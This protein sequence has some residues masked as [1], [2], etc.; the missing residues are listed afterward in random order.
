MGGSDSISQ[1]QQSQVVRGGSP[2]LA[3]ACQSAATLARE[4]RAAL[5]FS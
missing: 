1:P 4:R 3:I 2:G 5:R